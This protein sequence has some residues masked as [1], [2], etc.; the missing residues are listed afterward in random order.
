MEA[1]SCMFQPAWRSVSCF[2]ASGLAS[3]AASQQGIEPLTEPKKKHGDQFASVNRIMAW[4][5]SRGRC[6]PFEITV[7]SWRTGEIG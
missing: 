5:G 6:F 1:T 3:T 2:R 4:H 7:C